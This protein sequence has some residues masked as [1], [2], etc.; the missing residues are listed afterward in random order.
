ME[1]R[2]GGLGRSC[3]WGAKDGWWRQEHASLWRASDV[4]QRH[5]DTITKVLRGMCSTHSRPQALPMQAGGRE[6][7]REQQWAPVQQS[8]GD[9]GRGQSRAV[10]CSR[11]V[12]ASDL[13]AAGQASSHST[14]GEIH[15]PGG[16]EGRAWPF[17]WSS[18]TDQRA[19]LQG[20]R[21]RSQRWPVGQGWRDLR[22]HPPPER[23]RYPGT[24]QG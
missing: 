12:A 8:L 7:W 11:D 2:K 21:R 4:P 20:L 18:P 3:L 19:G 14:A 13:R 6:G 16:P 17:L 10:P 9:C 5:M 23:Q 15:C 22:A 1:A 24:P